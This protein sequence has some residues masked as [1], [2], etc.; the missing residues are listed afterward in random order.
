MDAAR[1]L[2]PEDRD[3]ANGVSHTSIGGTLSHI[4]LA[5]RLWFQRMTGS[6]DPVNWE[7]TW[8]ETQ[9]AWPQMQTKWEEWAATQSDADGDR[10]VN[11]R[12][13]NGNPGSTPVSLIVMH[14]VNHATLHRGQVVGMIRQLGVQ[15]PATDML[16]YFRELASPK[17]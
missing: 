15:P 1:Q 3:R 17:M 9:V 2:S 12:L 10:V 6:T 14:L 13:L 5:D 7:T 16:W 8:D 4:F 11:Y